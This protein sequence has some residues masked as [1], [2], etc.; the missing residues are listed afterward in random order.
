M[1]RKVTYGA[2]C[3]LDGYIA[4]P[5]G[6]VDWL[7]WSP[8]VQRLTAAYWARVDTVLMGRKT[9]DVA[10][11]LGTGAFPS[12]T[13]YV[14]SRTLRDDPERDVQLVRED[15]AAFVA[16][17]RKQAG[18]EICIMGGGEF[19]RTLF[20]ADLVDEVGVNI[21]PVLLGEGVLFLSVG[22]EIRLE[23]LRTEALAGDCIY[24]LYKVK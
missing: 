9:Y 10:K 7:H 12:V 5:D 8:D 11:A 24:A 4:R 15:A 21:Q 14:F 6:S 16:E 13:N 17:L 20:E 23:L 22:R 18:G 1:M 19:A 2:A 3:S